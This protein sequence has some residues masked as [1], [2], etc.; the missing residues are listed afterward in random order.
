MV[1]FVAQ[2]DPLAAKW[3]RFNDG[4][5]R[6]RSALNAANSD[7]MH[8]TVNAALT[9]LYELWEYWRAKAPPRPGRDD[10]FVRGDADGETT[11][12]LVYARGAQFHRVFQEHG[13]L[14]D[15]YTDTYHDYYGSWQWEHF[16]D[17]KYPTREGWYETHVAE[18]E[19]IEPF[20]VAQRWLSAQPELSRS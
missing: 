16:S 6:V 1:G 14:T 13:D 10:A 11:A 5:D 18:R 12:A 17:P 7:E 3:R 15:A 20:K 2:A 4:V 9:A 8:D 19:V